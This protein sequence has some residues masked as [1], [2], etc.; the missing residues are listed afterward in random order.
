MEFALVLIPLLLC[1]S[2]AV[3][4][5]FIFSNREAIINAARDGARYATTHPTA[6]SNAASPA[7]NTI[8]GQI[9]NDSGSASVSNDDNHIS[10]TYLTSTG[11]RCGNYSVSSNGFVA[12][13]GYTQTTCLVPGSLIQVQVTYQYHILTPLIGQIFSNV[14]ITSTATMV[15]EQ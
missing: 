12:Q 11:T 15:E 6:W 1:V 8:E 2:G 9:L 5:G 7:I 3:D 14:N 4:M 13:T 10:I